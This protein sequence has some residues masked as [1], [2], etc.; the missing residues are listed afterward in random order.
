[1]TSCALQ[2]SFRAGPGVHALCKSMRGVCKNMQIQKLH[3]DGCKIVQ[4]TRRLAQLGL[5][6]RSPP[7]VPVPAPVQR[8]EHIGQREGATEQGPL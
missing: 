8:P 4:K 3:G 2:E 7:P 1:M 5:R 6:A